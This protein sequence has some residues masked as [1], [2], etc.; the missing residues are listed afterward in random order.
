MS[1]DARPQSSQGQLT[2]ESSELKL[3]PAQETWSTRVRDL[4]FPQSKGLKDLGIGGLEHRDQSESKARKEAEARQRRAQREADKKAREAKR[5]ASREGAQKHRQ[6]KE[7]QK[8]EERKDQGSYNSGVFWGFDPNAGMLRA[9]HGTP[10]VTSPGGEVDRSYSHSHP[11][12]VPCVPPVRG[13]TW[14]VQHGEQTKSS[15][16]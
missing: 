11:S 15:E 16:S 13:Q 6:D 12:E 9:E 7:S 1:D 3:S 14:G 10:N 5:E 4:F 8:A 2:A